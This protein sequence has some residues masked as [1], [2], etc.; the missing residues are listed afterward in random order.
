MDNYCLRYRAFGS[1]SKKLRLERDESQ[2]APNPFLRVSMSLAPINPSD[3]IPITGAYAHRI[4]L[5]AVAGHEGV[6]K[7]VDAPHTH[8]ELIGQRVLPLRGRGTWQGFVD[9]DP[10]LAISVPDD[11]NDT[12][13]ARSYINPLAAIRMLRKWPVLGKRVLLTGAGSTCANLLGLWAQQEGA[14]EVIGVYRSSGRAKELRELGIEPL[15]IS[16]NSTINHIAKNVDVTFDAL[17]GPIATSILESMKDNSIFVGYGLLSGQQLAPVIRPQARY[18]RFHLRDELETL[19]TR[20]WQQ[21]FHAIW[22]RL[23]E[24]G[25]PGVRIFPVTNWREAID[26]FSIPG[27]EKPM[28]D[29]NRRSNLHLI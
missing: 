15:R 6:G 11:I 25:L 19:S 1:P 17:G 3:L 22:P 10:S 18:H 26:Y 5:P 28:L 24:T 2:D 8:A 23:R 4:K 9:C 29:L 12:A 21:Q 16:D 20:E 7:V 14:A 27:N 13:A